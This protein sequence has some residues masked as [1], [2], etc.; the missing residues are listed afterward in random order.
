MVK[1]TLNKLSEAQFNYL[2]RLKED[3]K[4]VNGDN[5]SYEQKRAFTE[6]NKATA[7]GYIK[8]LEHCGIISQTEFRALYS[9]FTV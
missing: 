7:R 8:A 6:Q 3:T 5:Y 4:R 1:E 9:W 2:N